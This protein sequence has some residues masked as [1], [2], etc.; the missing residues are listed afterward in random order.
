MAELLGAAEE[1]EVGDGLAQRVAQPVCL[2]R[3]EIDRTRSGALHLHAPR[4]H[5]HRKTGSAALPILV[6]DDPP[7]GVA[8]PRRRARRR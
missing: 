8:L 7:G 5:V 1:P 6:A 4:T 2:E 3:V